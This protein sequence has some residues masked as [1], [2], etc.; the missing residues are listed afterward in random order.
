M[1]QLFFSIILLLSIT[2]YGQDSNPFDN[3]KTKAAIEAY[4]Y[5]CI[6]E[7][8]LGF[9]KEKYPNVEQKASLNLSKFKVKYG[10]GEA[11]IK[12]Y[13]FKNLREDKII[14]LQNQIQKTSEEVIKEFDKWDEPKSLISIDQIIDL[15]KIENGKYARTLVGFQFNDKPI[16][17]LNAGFLQKVVKTNEFDSQKIRWQ[18]NVPTSWESVESSVSGNVQ[19][20][21]KYNYGALNIDL[22]VF[23]ESFNVSRNR[24]IPQKEL[25]KILKA[26]NTIKN[27]KLASKSKTIINKKVAYVFEYD[28]N[29]GGIA[30]KIINSFI[31]TGNGFYSISYLIKKNSVKQDLNVELKKY[32]PVFNI[33]NNSF[34]FYL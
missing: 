14:E 34:K 18:I 8:S 12:E 24:T 26:G 17:E 20:R 15:E 6:M 31:F 28:L 23:G 33:I 4:I 11:K 27:G 3:P 32:R 7:N 16:E 9:L 30:D 21:F 22:L 29:P 19:K 25:D 2:V 10:K 1:K 5:V 13:L